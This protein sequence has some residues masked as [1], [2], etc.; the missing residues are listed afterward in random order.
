MNKILIAIGLVAAAAIGWFLLFSGGSTINYVAEV[1]DEVMALEAELATIEAA[2]A[3][4]ELTPEQAAA[5]QIRIAARL[6]AIN[7]AI[8]KSQS[9]KLTEAQRVQLV[10]GLDRLKQVLVDY[11]STLVTVDAVVEA[12]PEAQRPQLTV[13]GST[14]ATKHSI[15][16][17]ALGTVDV[18]E[19]YVVDE[20]EDYVPEEI[21]AFTADEGVEE[22]VTEEIGGLEVIDQ[23]MSD[24]T[25]VMEEEIVSDTTEE[26]MVEE[27][28]MS[29]DE[30]DAVEVAEEVM[31]D[32]E[33]STEEPVIN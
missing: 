10:G 12:L 32:E 29:G 4:G 33:E 14:S 27:D 1:N 31:P 26:E 13:R 19:S 8:D 9:A 2:V 7:T 28:G 22:E 5:A 3:A 11:Q 23:D 21:E 6:E 16:A 24:E 25:G 15:V 18:V 30:T 17:A 20:V